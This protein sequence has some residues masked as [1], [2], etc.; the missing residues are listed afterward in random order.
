MTSRAK[1][2]AIAIV[3]MGAILPGATSSAE[4]WRNLMS[5]KELIREVPPTYWLPEDFYNPDW[6][7]P[8]KVYCKKGAFLDPIDFDPMKY[9]VP[10]KLLESTDTCQLLA[11]MVADQ[12]LEDSAKAR[13]A[14]VDRERIGC[15]L[16]ICSGL[17]LVGEMAGRLQ[18]PSYVK[19]LREHGLPEDDVQKISS[20]ITDLHAVW[21]EST[22]PGLLGNV[23]TGRITN[24]FD[25]GGPNFTTDAACASSFAA[26]SMAANLLQNRDADLIITGGADTANDPFTFMCFSKTPALSMSSV[27]APFSEK[28]DG[29]MLGEGLAMLALRRLEDA[30]RD[31]DRIY[32]VIRGWGASSDGKAKSIYAPRWEGQVKALQR[33][34]EAAGYGPETVELVEAHG[35]GTKAGDTAEFSA[36]KEVFDASKRPDRQWCAI[37]TIKSQM[38]HTKATAGAVGLLKTVLSLHNKVLPPTFNID[39][40]N[41]KLEIEKTPFYLNTQARP[42]F[43]RKGHPRRAAVSSFGFGGTNFHLTL[44]EYTG[45]R[46]SSPRIRALPVELVL[47]CD[48]D[49]TG[50]AKAARELAVSLGVGKSGVLPHV[51]RESQGRFRPEAACRLAILAASEDELRERLEQAADKI[52]KGSGATLAVPGKV[53]F[54]A[55]PPRSGGLAFLFSGQGSQYVG[56]G[57]DVAMAFDAARGIWDD[58]A[59]AS[60]AEIPLHQVVF[61]R[62]VFSDEER[63]AD[64]LRLRA[65]EWAQPSIGAVSASLLGLLRSVGLK[66]DCVAGHSF[67]E[68][69]ALYAAGVLDRTSFLTIARARGELMASAAG[70]NASGMTAVTAPLEQVES[71]LAG[72]EAVVANHNDPRQVVVSGTIPAIEDAEKRLAAAGLKFQRLSVAA[73]FHSPVVAASVEPFA[74]VL[75]RVVFERPAVDVFANASAAAYGSDPAA[76]RKQ[77][78]GSI[79]QR[80]RF[81]EMIEAMYARGVRTFVEVGPGGVLSSMVGRICGDRPHLAVPLD[82]PGKNGVAMLWQGLAQ[83]AVAGHPQDFAGLWAEFQLAPDPRAQPKPKMTV[84][85]SGTNYGKRYPPPGG[86][87]D[88]PPPN[89]PRAKIDS[90][91][92]GEVM[93]SKEHKSANESGANGANGTARETVAAM[94]R[95]PAHHALENGAANGAN[96]ASKTAAPGLATHANGHTAD[97]PLPALASPAWPVSAVAVQ[98]DPSSWLGAYEAIQNRTAEAHALYQQTMAQCHLAFLR[99]AEQ[100]AL[101]LASIASGGGLPLTTT[102]A[103]VLPAV[104][105]EA[106][107]PAMPVVHAPVVQRA[108]PVAAPAP[109]PVA[110]RP[111]PR[112]PAP[113]AEVRADRA[114]PPPAAVPARAPSAPPAPAPAATP[115]PAAAAPVSA[116]A[117]Q[118]APAAEAPKPAAAPLAMPADGDLK[119]YLFSIV[120][121]KTGYPADILNLEQQLEADLGIDSIKRVEILSAFEGQIPDIKDVNLEEVTKLNTLGDVLGFMERYADK[122][123]FAK[124]KE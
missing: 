89:P 70:G 90:G 21:N 49:R 20:A 110:A 85:I 33:C 62:P 47:L 8:D 84:S 63:D 101:A 37:G 60:V 81:V 25:L 24:H 72:S 3:G 43:A 100:S 122:L 94:P 41:A 113:V 96:G 28:A 103:A 119:T 78:A 69:S 46:E 48:K 15:I 23:V 121:E 83:L 77:L 106:L 80:V 7:V 58:E 67:G 91:R 115:A 109:A 5:G 29:T 2:D 82:R 34:Y 30:E 75:E 45:K 104:P 114:V 108:R 11:L 19:V 73:A 39:R 112:A 44:E 107:L 10:P 117:G 111:A 4:F 50:L 79:A 51:A 61:P 99:A 14:H 17:E 53:Y 88:L 124:K 16:G 59:A 68:V 120:S 105:A 52:E 54:S 56:M 13:F 32:A 12:V 95:P 9:G 35:T 38:G 65:T 123:G 86:A 87:A 92:N 66:P 27:C 74:R 118:A 64:E 116:L 71:L 98:S 26:V 40:P 31:G 97:A 6:R 102:R 93:E 42:W 57:G 36:L 18:R 1:E 76:I 22:F 55:E